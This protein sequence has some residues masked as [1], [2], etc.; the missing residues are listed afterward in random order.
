M[1]RTIRNITFVVLCA[2]VYVDLG[3]APVKAESMSCW[4]I[5]VDRVNEGECNERR[6]YQGECSAGTCW[7]DGFYW[8]VGECNKLGGL[9]IM[10][11]H[12]CGMWDPE[13]IQ[14]SCQRLCWD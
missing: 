13:P 1:V 11:E 9:W 4:S 7:D 5:E 3:S 6:D 8:A 2:M 14:Y 10:V 12:F